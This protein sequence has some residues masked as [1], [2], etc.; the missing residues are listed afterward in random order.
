MKNVN[1]YSALP[2]LIFNKLAR[3]VVAGAV[4]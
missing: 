1:L 2:Q 3:T 4:N